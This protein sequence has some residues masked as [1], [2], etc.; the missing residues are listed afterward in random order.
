[1]SSPGKSTSNPSP[2]KSVMCG[3]DKQQRTPSESFSF[4]PPSTIDVINCVVNPFIFAN[5]LFGYLGTLFK[6]KADT[7]SCVHVGDLVFTF[8][9]LFVGGNLEAVGK[10][11]LPVHLVDLYQSLKP[12]TLS[13]FKFVPS[14]SDFPDFLACVEAGNWS[15]VGFPTLL[16]PKTGGP[17]R[18]PKFLTLEKFVLLLKKF[19]RVVPRVR[20]SKPDLV[21]VAVYS[22]NTPMN[23]SSFPAD[24]SIPVGFGNGKIIYMRQYGY[25]ALEVAVPENYMTTLRLCT[26]S[27]PD[28]VRKDF[29]VSSVYSLPCTL[30]FVLANFGREFHCVS[31]KVAPVH[32]IFVYMHSV[33]E[34]CMLQAGRLDAWYSSFSEYEM[35]QL[36]YAI[37]LTVNYRYLSS[38]HGVVVDEST[39]CETLLNASYYNSFKD[40]KVPLPLNRILQAQRMLSFEGSLLIPCFPPIH[41]SSVD[42]TKLYSFSSVLSPVCR[43][44]DFRLFKTPCSL[45]E[46]YE[47]FYAHIAAFPLVPL[48]PNFPSYLDVSLF[49]DAHDRAKGYVSYFPRDTEELMA[50]SVSVAQFLLRVCPDI[51]DIDKFR[52]AHRFFVAVKYPTPLSLS[53]FYWKE[54]KEVCETL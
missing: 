44:R 14:F 45:L 8:M 40:V 22:F 54:L 50:A 9:H 27:G 36:M 39:V 3:R 31:L 32:S 4:P 21:S 19:K 51:L 24:L 41:F 20:V 10:N 7:R 28:R 52:D 25:S 42:I 11:R 23:E 2:S 6:F 33:L 16:S 47:V 18:C 46:R 5:F 38:S 43:N 13:N 49:L 35:K 30:G 1:M 34:M 17:A 29:A 26:P 15:R 48:I 37:W 12:I 53:D